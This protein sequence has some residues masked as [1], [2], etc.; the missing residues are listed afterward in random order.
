VNERLK[1]ECNDQSIEDLFCFVLVQKQAK[2]A[3]IECGHK[4]H[5][6]TPLELLCYGGILESR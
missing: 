5:A 1:I 2:A 3:K 6:P 4:V